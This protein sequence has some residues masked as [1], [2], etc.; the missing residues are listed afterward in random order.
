MKK[1]ISQIWAEYAVELSFERLSSEAIDSA[2]MFLYDSIGCALG[3]SKTEDFRILEK[4]FREIGGRGEC[5]VIGS[6]LKTDVRSASLI[7]AVAIRA[8]DYNDVYWKQDPSHPSDLLPAAFC[9]GEREGKNGKD[10]LT[11]IVIAYELEMRLMEA[12]FPGIRELGIHHATLTAFVSPVVAG[13]MLGLN[14]EQIANAIGISGSHSITLGAVTAG[15]LTMMKNTVDPMATE[16]GVFAALLAQKGY[17][18]PKAIFEG[19]EGL[20]DSIGEE[21]KPEVLTEGLGESFKI[22]ECSIKPFPSEALTHAPIS[23]VLDLVFEHDLKPDEIESIEV[24]TLK[25]AAEILADEKKYII[26]S[27]ETADHSLPYCIATAVVKRRLTPNEFTKEA[28]KDEKVLENIPKVRAV[29]EPSFEERFPAEQPCKVVIKLKDGRKFERERSYPKGDPRDKLSQEELKR[30]FSIL[31]EG[32]LSEEQ[33]QKVFEAVH[34]L[35]SLEKI[36]D[37]MRLVS[38][39]ENL[40]GV[41]QG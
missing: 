5:S 35:E 30:K 26:D 1:T 38:K 41:E 2:K 8:L 20:F 21:W 9:V 36:S 39:T 4:V 3:G 34:N 27:R 6:G 18:A 28:L 37:L 15:A 7:N 14:A 32:I 25:R 29:L 10:L 19:R 31:A 13:K 17:Q 16:A 11:A 33:Q 23:A 40:A 22:T 24:Y 12:A